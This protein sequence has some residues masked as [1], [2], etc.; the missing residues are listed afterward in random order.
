[1]I[2]PNSTCSSSQQPDLRSC[3]LDTSELLSEPN[4]KVQLAM[5]ND[6]IVVLATNVKDRSLMVSGIVSLSI[7]QLIAQ[8]L[9]QGKL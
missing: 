5:V 8:S 3:W 7:A 6:K 2:R 9:K 4:Q 1:M